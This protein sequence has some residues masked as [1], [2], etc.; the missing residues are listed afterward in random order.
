VAYFFY[1][2]GRA[3]G[4][5]E[6]LTLAAAW[7]DRAR[8]DV[9][10]EDAFPR[11]RG[12]EYVG[13]SA[14]YHSLPGIHCV[15]ALVALARR[16][17]VSARAAVGA[18]LRSARVRD[19]LYDL[20]TG[21][22][23][24]LLGA[25]AILDAAGKRAS[26]DHAAL[27]AMGNAECTR[28]WRKIDRLPPIAVSKFPQTLGI[29][30]GWAGLLYA[31][32]R[33]TESSGSPLPRT[34]FDRL[35]ELAERGII[36][37]ANRIRWPVW[38]PGVSDDRTS[39]AGWCKGVAGHVFLW[40]LASTVTG[41]ADFLM[42]AHGAARTVNAL[43]RKNARTHASLCC[44]APGMA[45]ALA[46]AYRHEGNRTWLTAARQL[47]ARAGTMRSPRKVRASLHN[48]ALGAALMQCEMRAA[49]SARMPLFEREAPAG[50]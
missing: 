19:G 5:A 2:L 50:A 4:D 31:T 18:F 22:A 9:G 7:V 17:D 40:T 41:D 34:T 44:G 13:P 21:R 25:A 42:L 37:D 45:Y 6:L 43:V 36:D 8:R 47:A 11:G 32:L 27:I 33:W 49:A 26:F 15:D 35:V 28:L 14:L 1:R 29:A 3:E 38:A 10:R 46:C 16:D 24:L 20:A 12:A 30:H 39:V 23:G 48:G